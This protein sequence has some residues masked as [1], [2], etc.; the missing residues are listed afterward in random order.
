MTFDKFAPF[1]NLTFS[2]VSITPPNESATELAQI[3]SMKRG[4]RRSRPARQMNILAA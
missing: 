3:A 4:S 1:G 2:T